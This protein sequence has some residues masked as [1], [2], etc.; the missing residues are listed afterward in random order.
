METYKQ[1]QGIIYFLQKKEKPYMLVFSSI[2]STTKKMLAIIGCIYYIPEQLF[3]KWPTLDTKSSSDV[4][5]WLH[6]IILL[7]LTPVIKHALICPNIWSKI[8][9]NSIIVVLLNWRRRLQLL[10]REIKYQYDISRSN[11]LFSSY[12]SRVRNI[13]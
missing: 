6:R 3:L 13:F 4:V 8:V 1:L 2:L 12:S 9:F 11:S 5:T 10:R 7:N